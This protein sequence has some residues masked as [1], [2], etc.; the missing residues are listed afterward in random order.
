MCTGIEIPLLLASTAVS[1]AGTMTQGQN[2]A[3]Q[4]NF[5]A[6]LQRQQA[7]RARQEAAAQ[8]SAIRRQ[9]S[10]E[11]SSLRARL[12]ASGVDVSG[13]SAL[14]ALETLSGDSELEA[15]TAINQGEFRAGSLEGSAEASRFSG[16]TA[17]Q[18]SFF[19]A[20]TTLLNAA[21]K[22]DF[23]SGELRK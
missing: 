8:A 7:D 22:I 3:K 13:G 6:A 15:L 19:S 16:R 9:R 5:Q 1:V 10:R 14:L 17:Q 2:A 20:G 11:Q 18:Q 21:G 23:E 4:A 12:S